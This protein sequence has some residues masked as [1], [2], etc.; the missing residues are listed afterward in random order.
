MCKGLG[1][2][3]Q[4]SV[5]L[6][7]VSPF[8]ITPAPE[9]DGGRGILQAEQVS[10]L[11]LPR[12][13][14]TPSQCT[15]R[16]S[17]VCTQ[18]PSAAKLGAVGSSCQHARPA[19]SRRL[20]RKGE[21]PTLQTPGQPSPGGTREIPTRPP[22]NEV[23]LGPPR[24]R[25]ETEPRERKSVGAGW[26]PAAARSACGGAPSSAHTVLGRAHWPPARATS[27]ADPSLRPEEGRDP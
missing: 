25:W 12:N 2:G 15:R 26:G 8:L 1:K 23:G 7:W 6:R 5:L 10:R 27:R 22:L 19:P 21:K 20:S 17:R 18:T 9:E 16:N 13:L 3:P 4:Q 24:A 11:L 14:G